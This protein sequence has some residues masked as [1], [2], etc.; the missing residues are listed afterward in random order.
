MK[1]CHMCLRVSGRSL[2]LTTRVYH[3]AN[4]DRAWVI[5]DTHDFAP[6]IV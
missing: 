1:R 2:S 3:F 5:S 6:G 4:F